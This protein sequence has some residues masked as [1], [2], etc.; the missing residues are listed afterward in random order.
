MKIDVIIFRKSV[1]NIQVS[2][3]SEKNNGFF[4]WRPIYFCDHIS[5]NSSYNGK[6]SGQKL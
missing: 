2:F 1:Q 5:P 4:T 6:I 3:K